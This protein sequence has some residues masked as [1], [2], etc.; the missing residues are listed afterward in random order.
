MRLRSANLKSC[1]QYHVAKYS[2][3]VKP[4]SPSKAT[5]EI[6][7]VETSPYYDPFRH[8]DREMVV[9]IPSHFT[10]PCVDTLYK[11]FPVSKV[12]T[13]LLEREDDSFSDKEVIF[14]PEQEP[15][16]FPVDF[17][18]NPLDEPSRELQVK[19]QVPFHES[20]GTQT[21]EEISLASSR[22]LK[23]SHSRLSLVSDSSSVR[24]LSIWLSSRISQSLHH[25]N[26]VLSRNSSIRSSFAYARSFATSTMSNGMSR[27]ELSIWDELIDKSALDL[28]PQRASGDELIS[29]YDRPCCHFVVEDSPGGICITCGFSQTH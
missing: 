14:I 15:T 23:R 4:Q 1:K 27:D 10:M 5:S 3:R 22:G 20:L 19:S 7:S 2:R 24:H 28:A 25:V 13:R 26:S 29:L 16:E 21:D 8:Y 12:D 11:Y 9:G 6:I 17:R 18:S